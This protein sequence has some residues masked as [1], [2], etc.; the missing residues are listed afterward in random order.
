MIKFEVRIHHRRIG[1]QE[2]PAKLLKMPN[3]RK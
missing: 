1:N 3:Q 2:L